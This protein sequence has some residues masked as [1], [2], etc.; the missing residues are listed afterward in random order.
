MQIHKS[1]SGGI[2]LLRINEFSW[3]HNAVVDILNQIFT[4]FQIN[5][6]QI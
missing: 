3:K 2:V 4:Q 6:Q 1:G 5:V